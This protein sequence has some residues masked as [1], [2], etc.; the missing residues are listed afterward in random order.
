MNDVVRRVKVC[1]LLAL[2]VFAWS[3]TAECARQVAAAPGQPARQGIQPQVASPAA[4]AVRRAPVS[5]LPPAGAEQT[6][7]QLGKVLSYYSP[8]LAR[9]L[10]MDPL[11]L[12]N[13]AYLEPYPEL[14]TFLGQHPEVTRNASYYFA[15]FRLNYEP[16]PS[17]DT[18]GLRMW[19]SMF[20]GFAIFMVFGTV[21]GALIWLVKTL[22][23]YRRWYRL[24]KVQTEAHNKLLDRFTANEE[25]LGYINTPS[26][27]RFLESAPIMLD[28]AGSVSSPLKRILWAVEIGAV[29]ACGAGGILVARWNV[30]AELSQPLF[31]A[32]VFAASLGVGFI[33]AAVASFLISKR[34]GV[35]NPAAAGTG[36]IDVPPAV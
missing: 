30:P 2:A 15:E 3:G 33:V 25:L 24:S 6:R 17:R 22:V 12:Q 35:L 20:E 32:G 27:R 7:E 14:V 1:A 26:G 23:D 4:P 19:R 5:S 21:T 34:L 29:L 8:N 10:A 28:G 31:V 36:R 16:P 13:A 11:L 9:V 18:E